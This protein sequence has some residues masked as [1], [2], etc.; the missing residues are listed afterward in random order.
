MEN[1]QVQMPHKVTIQE[2]KQLTMTGVTE[3]LSFDE[4]AV[5]LQTGLGNLVVQG[6]GLRLK[7]L[8]PE[9]GQVRIDGTICALFYEEPRSSKGG[10]G[11]FFR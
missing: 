9:G 2:R 5:I 7:T 1:G 11:R 4:E 8:S 3:I 10:I 6:K